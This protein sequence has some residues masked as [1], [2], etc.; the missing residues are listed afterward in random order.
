MLPLDVIYKGPTAT[1]RTPKTLQ[2]QTFGLG[3]H[4]S[5]DGET[6]GYVERRRRK[7]PCARDGKEVTAGQG[8]QTERRK[9]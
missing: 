6:M 8:S 5:E 7:I 3:R 2:V 9:I 1:K 4:S